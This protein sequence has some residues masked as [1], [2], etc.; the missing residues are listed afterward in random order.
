MFSGLPPRLETNIT[1]VPSL[2]MNDA[3]AVNPAKL[4]VWWIHCRPRY[5]CTDHPSP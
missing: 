2:G 5:D 4:P 3:F 1:P